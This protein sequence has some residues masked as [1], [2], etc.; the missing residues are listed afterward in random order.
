MRP[1]H[2]LWS[3]LNERFCDEAAV[4]TLKGID[5]RPKEIVPEPMA[6]AELVM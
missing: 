6:R 5:T 1:P 2:F 3:R 4:Y